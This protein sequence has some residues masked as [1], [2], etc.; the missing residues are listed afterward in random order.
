[1]QRQQARSEKRI[2]VYKWE[3]NIELLYKK[4]ETEF[5]Q[6]NFELIKKYDR[7]MVSQGIKKST[8][9]LHLCRLLSLTRKLNKD[10]KNA[11]KDDVKNVIFDVMDRY[12]D[13][14]EDTE[15]TY[16]H[17]KVLKIFLRWHKL[18]NRSYQY[19]LKKYRVGDPPETEDI[20]MKKPK[21]KLKK[22]DLISDTEKQWLLDACQS[23]RDKALI[24]V[25]LDS[26]I[27][28]GELL[29]L[30]IKNVM[31]D[32]NGFVINVEG[33]TGIR[34]VLL[35]QSTPSLARWLSEHPFRENQNAS[36]WVNLEKTKYGQP[37]AYSAV[38]AILGRIRD[39]AKKKHPQ[40]KKP[41]FLNLFRH[42]E[43]TN[44]AKWMSHAITKKR[45]GW[46]PGSK[47][48]DRYSHLD[49]S[50][51]N[52]IIY[53]HYGIEMD[54]ENGPKLP[55][56]CN[57]CQMVNPVDSTVCSQCGKPL[58]LQTALEEDERRKEWNSKIE[59][60]LAATTETL[61]DVLESFVEYPR[62]IGPN[63]KVHPTEKEMQEHRRMNEALLKKLK[64]ES[65]D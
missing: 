57:I 37:L 14:G 45:H 39:R 10:W 36:L 58:D 60:K 59:K 24:D 49:N 54:E 7:E 31:H 65:Y 12:S 41:V 64:V 63:G 50:D 38:R 53:K 27:R 28:P 26:G 35:V 44:T 16:D 6:S 34:P 8:R 17:K 3:H 48:P 13:D 20:V 29:S 52:E 46:S 1:M 30:K 11:T 2:E 25:A 4:I 9:F 5:S 22:D 21:S 15:Y 18:G 23:T 55:I 61:R 56:K 42:T 43:A 62:M 33:K 32:K 47:M 51:V 19:C 40:F